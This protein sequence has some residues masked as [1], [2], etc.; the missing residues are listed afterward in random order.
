MDKIKSLPFFNG[1]RERVKG[2][3]RR[4]LYVGMTRAKDALYSLEH[5]GSEFKWLVNTGLHPTSNNVWGCC[6]LSP[7]EIIDVATESDSL[8]EG[9]YNMVE[10]P[11]VRTAYERK[12]LSPSRIKDFV[13]F[14]CHKLLATGDKGISTA[15]WR[16]A[17][18]SEIGSCI[19]D[20]FAVCRSGEDTGNTA[21]AKS[22]I[23]GYG[24]SNILSSEE[25]LQSAAW[26]HN[27]LQ[28]KFP[29]QQG[30]STYYEY[31]FEA[32]IET[33][34]HLRGEMDMLWFYTDESGRHCVLVDYKTF[35]GVDLNG[36]VKGY[37]SQLS[38][39]AY[40]LRKTGI[41]VT[42]TLVYYP[43]QKCIMRLLENGE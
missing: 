43:V 36:H 19:H 29:Q 24:L 18:Y 5:Y 21:K 2:E 35:P 11:G 10:K 9:K 41:D 4:L 39:Y 34:Q 15:H 17:E 12:Y 7:I 25:I 42:H 27:K 26:L 13:G 32:D 22:V 28:E 14:N 6:E 3:E 23:E 30:D 38:A 40:A 31:P 33:G 16:E 8:V 1:L 20:V 37:Y